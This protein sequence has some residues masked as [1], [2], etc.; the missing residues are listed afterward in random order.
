MGTAVQQHRA[1]W[2]LVPTFRSLIEPKMKEY[3]DRIMIS[4]PPADTR[5]FN[6]RV[7][8]TFGE[9]WTQ[10]VKLA[11]WLR[12]YGCGIGTNVGIGGANSVE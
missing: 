3:W 5:D 1:D 12:A 10:S 6:A 8:V 9:V 4:S 11:A 2:Q 7:R